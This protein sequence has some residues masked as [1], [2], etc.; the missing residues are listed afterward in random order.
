MKWRLELTLALS[1][2]LPGNVLFEKKNET[3]TWR[4]GR[5]LLAYSVT[6]SDKVSNI[7]FSAG[8]AVEF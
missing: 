6:A 4:G 7:G 1:G 5:G 2:Y 3:S 8:N